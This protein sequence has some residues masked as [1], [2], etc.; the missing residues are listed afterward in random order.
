MVMK[1]IYTY[2]W[3]IIILISS[4]LIGCEDFL[5]K[6]PQGQLTQA[7]FPVTASDALF[8]GCWAKRQ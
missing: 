4:I 3:V 5:E 8:V 6:N 7:T 2:F 1:N